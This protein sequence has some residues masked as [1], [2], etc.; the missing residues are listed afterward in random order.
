MSDETYYD[1]EYYGKGYDCETCGWSADEIT[2]IEYETGTT[3]DDQQWEVSISAGC[4]GGGNEFFPT[5]ED[6]L[7]YL[8]QQITMTYYEPMRPAMAALASRLKE[9]IG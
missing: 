1:S 8:T 2:V 7:E 9:H 3:I 5:A 6:A 4:F